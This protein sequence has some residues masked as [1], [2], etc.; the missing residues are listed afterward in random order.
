MKLERKNW[1]A[2]GAAVC[3]LVTA[4]ALFSVQSIAQVPPPGAPP[5]PPMGMGQMPMGGA[6]AQIVQDNQNLFVLRGNVIY[7]IDKA[8]MRVTGQAELPRPT[9]PAGPRDGGLGRRPGGGA[10]PPEEEAEG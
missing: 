6:Q 8:Q 2:Y 9:P 4:G 3:S 1:I 5:Q 7:K 10:P